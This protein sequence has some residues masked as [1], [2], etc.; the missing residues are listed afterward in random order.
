MDLLLTLP[1]PVGALLGALSVPYL[2][3][4][5]RLA[6]GTAV[7]RRGVRLMRN[8]PGLGTL[9]LTAAWWS[10]YLADTVPVPAGL[11]IPAAVYLLTVSAVSWRAVSRETSP[12]GHEAY[13]RLATPLGL[14]VVGA[15]LTVVGNVLTPVLRPLLGQ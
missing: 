5:L 14:A 12:A 7:A 9:A 11:A 4:A 1:I 8:L 15:A 2:A 3:C 6:T 10:P 13:A